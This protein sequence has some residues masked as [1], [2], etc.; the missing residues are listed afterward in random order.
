MCE[1]MSEESLGV[2]IQRPMSIPMFPNSWTAAN[3]DNQVCG[4]CETSCSM[5]KGR[6]LD[7]DGI[8]PLLNPSQYI[9]KA[10]NYFCATWMF[11]SVL[12]FKI[13]R[14]KMRLLLGRLLSRSH[15]QWRKS[16]Y[17]KLKSLLR[18]HRK[19]QVTID[20][21]NMINL[22]M[23]CPRMQTALQKFEVKAY[24]LKLCFIPVIKVNKGLQK[25]SD[26]F[27]YKYPFCINI[28]N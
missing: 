28:H 12:H 23:Q 8:V 10:I 9:W 5:R 13:P 7:S 20:I 14:W 26:V 22:S 11:Q 17:C 27:L 19:M 4:C 16:L 15:N 1:V 3:G 24:I 6:S 25:W 18:C 21:I 2:S